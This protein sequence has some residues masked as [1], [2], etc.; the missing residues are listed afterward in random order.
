[1]YRPQSCKLYH[2]KRSNLVFTQMIKMTLQLAKAMCNC[3]PFIKKM[4]NNFFL[5]LLEYLYLL[6]FHM[7]LTFK[8][9]LLLLH[10]FPQVDKLNL[11]VTI[12]VRK[13]Y[14]EQLKD[15]EHIVVL[16]Q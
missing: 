5:I 14:G 4:F 2:P 11:E 3:H 1:M 6:G 10:R 15:Q 16:S 8:L 13:H 7:T 12:F 9:L